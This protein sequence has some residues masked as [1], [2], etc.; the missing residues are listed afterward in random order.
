MQRSL[1]C[2]NT[3]KGDV[4][5]EKAKLAKEVARNVQV[6]LSMDAPEPETA[7]S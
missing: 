3:Q 6:K 2:P 5:A 1:D 7:M 4:L